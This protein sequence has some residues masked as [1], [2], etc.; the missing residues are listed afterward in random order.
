MSFFYWLPAYWLVALLLYAASPRQQF[1]QTSALKL[2]RTLAISCVLLVGIASLMYLLASGFDLVVAMIAVL[3][4]LMLLIP[5][6][7][8]LLSH[9]PRWALRSTL[10]VTAVAL[11]LAWMGGS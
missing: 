5:A 7:V 3:A 10:L 1:L 4:G 9:Q 6:P 2:N 11:G 8:F